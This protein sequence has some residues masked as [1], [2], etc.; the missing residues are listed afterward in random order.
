M[1]YEVG[2][3]A[4]KPSGGRSHK[5]PP[6][7]MEEGIYD[8]REKGGQVFCFWGGK[9]KKKNRGKAESRLHPASHLNPAKVQ[10][11]HTPLH[12]FGAKKK[13]ITPKPTQETN[14]F[15]WGCWGVGL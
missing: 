8:H 15:V 9:Q 11:P 7:G 1:F 2:K 5:V 12:S 4:L 14:K 13:R 6:E 10:P 3:A